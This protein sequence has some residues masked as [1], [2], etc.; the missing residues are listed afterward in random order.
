MRAGGRSYQVKAQSLHLPIAQIER[1]AFAGIRKSDGLEHR[2][3]LL[4]LHRDMRVHV[5]GAIC[6]APTNRSLNEGLPC[7][8]VVAV[9]ESVRAASTITVESRR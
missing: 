8:G 5:S 1:L 7:P 3:L 2:P 4:V 6:C 9:R